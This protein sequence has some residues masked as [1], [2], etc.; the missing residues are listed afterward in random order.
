M[1]YRNYHCRSVVDINGQ[2]RSSVVREYRDMKDSLRSGELLSRSGTLSP[3]F[4]G[5][6]VLFL[7]THSPTISQAASGSTSAMVLIS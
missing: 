2:A 6:I 7:R 3:G 5:H 4:E 1:G